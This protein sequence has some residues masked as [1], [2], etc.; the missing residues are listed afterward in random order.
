MGGRRSA[1]SQEFQPVDR[2]V[3]DPADDTTSSSILVFKRKVEV[4]DTLRPHSVVIEAQVTKNEEDAD[5][6]TL[7]KL[8]DSGAPEKFSHCYIDTIDG[9]LILDAVENYVRQGKASEV[10]RFFEEEGRYA[11]DPTTFRLKLDTALGG[12]D[13]S[14]ADAM[15]GMF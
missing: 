15:K 3:F 1:F 14:G 10:S 7:L 11:G 2:E 9:E 6:I 4:T 5:G 8:Y 13:L 12:S